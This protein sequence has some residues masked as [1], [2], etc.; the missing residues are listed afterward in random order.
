MHPGQIP[1]G[2]AGTTLG[3]WPERALCARYRGN[4]TSRSG[5]AGADA[6]AGY[7]GCIWTRKISIQMHEVKGSV[8]EPEERNNVEWFKAHW[9]QLQT[10][11][12]QNPKQ[13]IE[14]GGKPNG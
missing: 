10:K 7:V 14:L 9:Y 13:I 6:E 5:T 4:T 8:Y 1:C 11:R 2:A 12:F 3:R